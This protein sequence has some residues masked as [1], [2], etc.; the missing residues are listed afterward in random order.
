MCVRS[1][2]MKCVCVLMYAAEKRITLGYTRDDTVASGYAVHLENVCVD[3]N[4]VALYRAQQDARRDGRPRTVHMGGGER[5]NKHLSF[6]RRG[7][8][9]G[10]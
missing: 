9:K 2:L 7:I 5:L 10:L 8:P 1:D 4:L 3:P 6:C